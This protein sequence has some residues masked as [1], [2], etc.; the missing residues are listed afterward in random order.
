MTTRRLSG[1]HSALDDA[2]RAGRGRV[3]DLEPGRSEEAAELL[4]RALLPTGQG[5]AVLV[6]QL[7]LLR[8][9]EAGAD[10]RVASN[11]SCRPPVDS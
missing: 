8:R 10:L 1:P 11:P 4:P 5:E 9:L 6:Y 7:T 3:D 2:H